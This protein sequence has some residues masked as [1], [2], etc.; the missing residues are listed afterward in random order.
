MKKEINRRDNGKGSIAWETGGIQVGGI[1]RGGIQGG[2]IQGG[3][4]RTDS[5][6][7]S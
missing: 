5:I 7:Y 6:S 3:E 1:Q 4:G 2:G